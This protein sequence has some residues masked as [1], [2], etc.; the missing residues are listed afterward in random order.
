MYIVPPLT[1]HKNNSTLAASCLQCGYNLFALFLS[2]ICFLKL[3]MKNIS[4]WKMLSI[5]LELFGPKDAKELISC[6][7]YDINRETEI[8]PRVR[9]TLLVF[10][11]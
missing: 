1:K 6:C 10:V 5:N 4:V 3:A 8:S 2:M 11:I 7:F 9:S